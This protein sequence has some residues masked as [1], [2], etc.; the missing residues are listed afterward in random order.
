MF[1]NYKAAA[2]PSDTDT[3]FKMVKVRFIKDEWN[4]LSRNLL[5]HYNGAYLVKYSPQ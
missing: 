3:K 2:T 4:Q 5:F 1:Q